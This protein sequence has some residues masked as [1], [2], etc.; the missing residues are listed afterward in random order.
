MRLAV[1]DLRHLGG[2]S[3]LWL[4]VADLRGTTT[5]SLISGYNVDGNALCA[6]ALAVQIVEGTREALVPDS[7]TGRSATSG[8]RQRTIAAQG[9]ARSLKSTGLNGLVELK[10]DKVISKLFMYLQ[11]GR[12][13][14]SLL[15][16]TSNVALAPGL[17]LEDTVGQ[18][19][20]KRA[21]ELTWPKVT[22]LGG[23]DIDG[24]DLEGTRGRCLT[25]SWWGGSLRHSHGRSRKG[26][27]NER[28]HF[29]KLL[30]DKVD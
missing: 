11:E 22:L 16:V 10:P 9:E 8:E 21:S 20:S 4:T 15:E 6:S 3:D 13:G 24:G 17:V 18:G 25:S 28:L 1:R 23:G 27:S 19:E 30:F 5:T 26:E 7:R 29:H 2:L 12:R 14:S